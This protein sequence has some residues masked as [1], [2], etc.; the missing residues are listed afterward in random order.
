MGVRGA[1]ATIALAA[2]LLAGCGDDPGVQLDDDAAWRTS[3]DP[4]ARGGLTWATGSTVHLGDGTT[5]ETG[6]PV[7]AFVVAG[8][9]VFYEP[10][11][12][13]EQG[14]AS[15]GGGPLM[16]AAPGDEPVDTGLEARDR[17]IAVSPDGTTLVLLETDPGRGS[18][19][20]RFFDLSTGEA[21]TSE[22]GMT[23]DDEDPE[24]HLAEAEVHVRG[25]SEESVYASVLEGSYVYDLD[26]GEGHPAAD[27]ED[28]PGWSAGPLESPDGR[29]RI[30]QGGTRPD[31]V[32]G[33]DGTSIE[34]RLEGRR[35]S[36]S[37][38]ADEETVVGT[39][40]LGAARGGGAGDPLTLVS[41]VVPSGECAPQEDSTG[42]LVLFPAGSSELPGLYLQGVEE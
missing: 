30:E 15:F 40:A 14:S 38:W 17:A 37:W 23:G 5:I 18:A 34:L 29:W 35:P 28:P 39:V 8:D 27:D 7:R 10:A 24:H 6:D 11:S 2:T 42:R 36:L 26:T 25:I 13:D 12:S 3:T 9:G 33:T 41:C 16:F 22:D 4:V 21:F 20:M 31:R 32:V 19:V 1:V